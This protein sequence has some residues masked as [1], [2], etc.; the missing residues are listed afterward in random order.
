MRDGRGGMVPAGS[1]L[2]LLPY[3]IGIIRISRWLIDFIIGRRGRDFKP[4]IQ[5]DLQDWKSVDRIS[6]HGLLTRAEPA[7]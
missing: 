4:N 3:R 7:K 5:I 2:L 6:W 1:R